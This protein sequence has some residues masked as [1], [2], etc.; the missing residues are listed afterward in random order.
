MLQVQRNRCTSST[1]D[2]TTPCIATCTT[3]ATRRERVQSTETECV[4]P[5]YVYIYTPLPHAE[6]FTLVAYAKDHKF[7]KEFV[8]D[9]LTD[10]ETS[11]GLYTM[12]CVVMTLTFIVQMKAAYWANLR[13]KTW[14][15]QKEQ[16]VWKYYYLQSA[17]TLR[18][19]ISSI[20]IC[21]IKE[22]C[23]DKGESTARW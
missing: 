14:S 15:D 2:A 18:Y 1:I 16:D 23:S 21:V 10:E 13:V 20:Y 7:D 11:T 8:P 5:K 3:L 9:L 19:I 4:A 17:D 22:Q 6:L 12:C